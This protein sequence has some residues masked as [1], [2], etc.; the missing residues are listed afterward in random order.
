MSLANAAGTGSTCALDRI[1]RLVPPAE[2]WKAIGLAEAAGVDVVAYESENRITNT[3][4]ARLAQGDRPRLR[5]DPGHVPAH[6]GHHGRRALQARARGGPGARGERR[7]LRQGPGRPP[8]RAGPGCCSSAATASTAA[9]S[10]SL[11]RARCPSWAATT[12]GPRAHPRA[13][14]A[15]RRRHRLRELHVA[16]PGRSRTR[17]TWSTATTTARPPGGQAPGSLLRARD[18]VAGRG[19]GSRRASLVHRH[20]TLHFVGDGAAL[21]AVARKVLGVGLA[22]IQAAFVPRTT[23][24]DRARAPRPARCCSSRAAGRPKNRQRPCPIPSA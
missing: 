4:G 16:D 12:P 8:G 23:P 22:E 3:G 6:A 11:R 15:A 21:D 9:R 20:R 2:A 17:A 14:H 19:P 5:L 24:S 10:A 18:L 13:V 1:V 7:L